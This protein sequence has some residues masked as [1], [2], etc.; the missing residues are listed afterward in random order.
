MAWPPGVLP[1]NRT[2]ATLQQDIHPVDH[3]AANQAIN[4]IV[5]Q[6]G[7]EAARSRRISWKSGSATS[8]PSGWVSVTAASF[9]LAVIEG[10][11]MTIYDGGAPNMTET[12]LTSVAQPGGGGS[13][14]VAR[15]S[16]IFVAG[17]VVNWGFVPNTPVFYSAV[18][19]G[20]PL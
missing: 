1:I 15:V 4:D 10:G 5:A 20:T 18:A 6:V 9:S 2:N 13:A 7:A 12:L 19:F 17:A 14:L 16:K 3:N 8:D 11:V